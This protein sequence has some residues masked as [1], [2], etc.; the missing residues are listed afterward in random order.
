LVK[1]SLDLTGDPGRYSYRLK[2]ESKGEM[3][4]LTAAGIAAA[5]E[6]GGKLRIL[7]IRVP[8]ENEQWQAMVR[9]VSNERLFTHLRRSLHPLK[10]SYGAWEW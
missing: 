1:L 2:G 5:L 4:L 7:N 6:A 3:L 10:P 9:P 8:M